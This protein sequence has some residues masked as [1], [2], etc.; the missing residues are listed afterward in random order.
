M[1]YEY[2]GKILHVHLSEM[3]L[4]VETPS[5]EFFQTYVGGSD[6]GTHY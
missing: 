3:H 5:E 1:P 6:L 4:E 2:H